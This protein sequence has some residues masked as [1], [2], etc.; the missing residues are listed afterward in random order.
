[1]FDVDEVNSFFFFM[2]MFNTMEHHLLHKRHLFQYRGFDK[3]SMVEVNLVPRWCKKYTKKN[4]VI[5]SS[6]IA[7]S[8]RFMLKLSY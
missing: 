8:A 3:N 4:V 2:L 7:S 5:V 6:K 1:M